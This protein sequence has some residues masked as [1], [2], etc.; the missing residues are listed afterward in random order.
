M[1]VE[2]TQAIMKAYW[3][4]GAMSVVADDAVYTNM[5]TGEE[6]TGRDGVAK[7]LELYYRQAFDATAED[8]NPLFG[9]NHAVLECFL[10]GKHVGPFQGIAPTGRTIW[11]PMCIVYPLKDDQIQRAHIYVQMNILLKQLGVG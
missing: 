4:Q 7:L 9:E 11:A 6:I 2:R 3:E 1:S 5:A 10:I 8:G